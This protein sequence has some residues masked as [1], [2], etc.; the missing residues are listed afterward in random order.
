MEDSFIAMIVVPAHETAAI[1][2]LF[3]IDGKVAQFEIAGRSP[4]GVMRTLWNE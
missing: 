1:I 4:S 3:S 2:V